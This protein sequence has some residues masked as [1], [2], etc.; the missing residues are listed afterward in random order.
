M[1][2]FLAYHLIK[3]V[4]FWGLSLIATSVLFLAPLIYK[5][6]QEAI[7]HY[8]AEAAQIV[9]KQTEQVKTIAS[10]NMARATST[11]KQYVG[12]YSHKAQELISN[13]RRSSS[14]V[15]TKT[16]HIDLPSV[17]KTE[18]S[19]PSVGSSVNAL[20]DEQEPLIAA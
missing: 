15:D 18:I 9:N 6:N 20:R 14:P 10:E 2:A 5:T 4:P 11:T 16:P 7:D 13:A 1:A 17:P 19:A 12:D 8:V 3:F